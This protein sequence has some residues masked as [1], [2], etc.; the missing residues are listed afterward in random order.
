M[1]QDLRR[2]GVEGFRDLG[3]RLYITAV[4]VQRI[5]AAGVRDCGLRVLAIALFDGASFLLRNRKP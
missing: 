2:L 5:Q 1:A 3:S 4:G